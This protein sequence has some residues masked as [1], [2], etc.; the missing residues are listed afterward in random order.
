MADTDRLRDLLHEMERARSPLQRLRLVAL[1]WRTIRGLSKKEREALALKVGMAEA[2]ELVERLATKDGGVA[3]TELLE[4]IHAAETTD[5]DKLRQ[6]VG[7]VKGVIRDPEGRRGLL[8]R[9][10]EALDA[11]AAHAVAP[12]AAAAVAA[13][14]ITP[15]D[16]VVRPQ[17]EPAAP[18]STPGPESHDPARPH[19]APEP[20]GS[21]PHFPCSPAPDPVDPP[22]GDHAA[23]RN[24]IRAPPAPRTTRPPL[25]RTGAAAAG[26]PPPGGPPDRVPTPRRPAGGRGARAAAPRDRPTCRPAGPGAARSRVAR[27]GPAGDHR[28]GPG[29]GER[30]RARAGPRLVS[31][32]PGPHPEA[33][34]PGAGGCPRAGELRR[35]RAGACGGWRL[36]TRATGR[37]L[38]SPPGPDSPDQVDRD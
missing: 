6:L 17:P 31:G 22:A 34:G 3:P 10:A 36:R 37:G 4:A 12:T 20:A 16:G 24:P 13:G 33:H 1:A 32:H 35:R 38:L 25:P 7:D 29:A 15:P 27:G 2:G 9:A 18:E 14:P 5:P 8:H 23:P 11:A 28:R 30:P 21:P 19:R 26:R